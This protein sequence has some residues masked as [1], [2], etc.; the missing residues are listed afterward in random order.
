MTAASRLLTASVTTLALPAAALA[1][2]PEGQGAIATMQQGFWTAITALI[3]FAVVFAVLATKVW[4]VIGKALDER[5]DK[6]KSEIEAAEAARAQAKAALDQYERALADA[7]VEAQKEIEKA[8]AQA[9]AI[10][11]ELKAKADTELSAM[12]D[13]AMREIDAAKKLALSEI[14]AEASGLGTMIAG[15]ILQREINRGDQ[16]RLVED[17]LNE[18]KAGAR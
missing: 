15:K 16:G 6:I 11:N 2:D 3:V 9:T 12:K 8:K 4:P 13:K 1:A 14:Y 5:A 17:A 10:A 7:R 18:M